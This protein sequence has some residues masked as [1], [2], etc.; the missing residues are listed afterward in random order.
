VLPTAGERRQDVHREMLIPARAA[1]ESTKVVSPERAMPRYAAFWDGVPVGGRA[2]RLEDDGAAI[3][4]IGDGHRGQR[5][6]PVRRRFESLVPR[7]AREHRSLGAAQIAKRLDRRGA[8][9]CRRVLEGR[10]AARGA[11]WRRGKAA[12]AVAAPARVRK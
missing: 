12:S 2:K 3:G 4:R 6:Q 5:R 7:L 11:P 10:S 1:T 9:L 8:D